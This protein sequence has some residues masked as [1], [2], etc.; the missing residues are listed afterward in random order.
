MNKEITTSSYKVSFLDVGIVKVITIIRDET[1]ENARE[2]YD[3]IKI[4]TENKKCPVLVDMRLQKSITRE[5][6]QFYSR[7]ESMDI[8]TALALFVESPI[9]KV[10]ANFYLGLNKPPCPTRLFTSED[11]AREWL[12]G[13]LQ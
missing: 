9:S 8:I 1:I 11:E 13:Y 3:I 12:R 5:A 2:L 6:R 10:L 4:V 7:K